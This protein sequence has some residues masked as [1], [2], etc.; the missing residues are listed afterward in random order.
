MAVWVNKVIIIVKYSSII[1]T[2]KH[3][4]LLMQYLVLL[5][6][7]PKHTKRSC[8]FHQLYIP[9]RKDVEVYEAKTI[10]IASLPQIIASF[11]K[12]NDNFDED[13]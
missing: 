3:T 4:Q 7:H 5:L 8:I 12:S 11:A 2:S 10:M 13:S 6:A 1:A 9:G